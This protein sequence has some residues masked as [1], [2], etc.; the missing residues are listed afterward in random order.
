MVGQKTAV[1]GRGG[2]GNIAEARAIE[3]KR[4]KELAE[5]E[6]AMRKKVAEEAKRDV[7]GLAVP[8][9][10]FLGGREREEVGQRKGVGIEAGV[11]F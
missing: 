1:G 7:D 11:P 3:A 8:G 10:A 5:K 6:E 2:A 9:R 4:Q